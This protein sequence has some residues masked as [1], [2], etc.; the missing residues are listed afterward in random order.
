MKVLLEKIKA[1]T[2]KKHKF[3]SLKERCDYERSL[4]IKKEAILSYKF[5]ILH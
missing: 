3:Y 5:L 4:E 1:M 2:E